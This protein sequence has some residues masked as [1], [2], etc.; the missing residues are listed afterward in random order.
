MARDIR[1]GSVVA[2]WESNTLALAVVGGEDRQ[3][4]RLVQ[5]RGKEVRV[6]GSR[7]LFEV[8]PPAGVPGTGL[9]ER[10]RAGERV[11]DIA[12]RVE[13]MVAAIEV[14]LLWEIVDGDSALRVSPE[15]RFV[16]DPSVEYGIKLERLIQ[17]SRG[18]EVPGDAPGDA[19]GDFHNQDEQE[20]QEDES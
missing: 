4:V 15:V 11:A 12:R 18:P 5:E 2:F 16:F 10:R 17:E 6:K 3:R 19:A 20:Q 7:I 1:P 13:R 8:G 14:P 9:E